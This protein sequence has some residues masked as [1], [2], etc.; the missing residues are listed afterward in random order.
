LDDITDIVDS[1][2]QTDPTFRTRRLYTRLSAVAVRQTLLTEKGYSDEELPSAETIGSKLNALGYSL[3]K[4]E[5]T[6]PQ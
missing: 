3:K 6:K 1:Q 4:V 2:S 5:K